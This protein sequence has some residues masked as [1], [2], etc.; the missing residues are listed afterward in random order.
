[1]DRVRATA[2]A[3]RHESQRRRGPKFRQSDGRW[4]AASHRQATAWQR[5]GSSIDSPGEQEGDYVPGAT[6][7]PYSNSVGSVSPPGGQAWRKV[8]D[9]V[10]HDPI[11]LAHRSGHGPGGREACPGPAHP[12]GDDPASAQDRP[13]PGREQRN[14]KDTD[15][16]LARTLGILVAS[17]AL[18]SVSAP[19]VYA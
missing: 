8:D 18:A 5:C 14:Q 6:L 9:S 10:P 1:M 7:W 16:K 15:M 4:P 12:R 3:A 19:T 11:D 17:A 13:D 2:R